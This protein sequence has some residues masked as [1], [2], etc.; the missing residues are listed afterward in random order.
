MAMSQTLQRGPVSGT[1]TSRTT[2]RRPFLLDLYATA[3]GK[4]Y[5]MAVTGII[6]ILFIIGHMVGNLKAYIGLVEEADGTMAYDLD[7]YA[8][9]SAS[10]SCPSCPPASP[11]GDC[12]SV[13]S[14]PRFC[15]SMRRGR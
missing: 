8:I 4:K 7:V 12:P 15:I 11:C 10:C 9:S 14:A 2:S 3:V 1:A 5:V 6:G 13:L